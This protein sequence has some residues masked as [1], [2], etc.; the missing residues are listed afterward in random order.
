MLAKSFANLYPR[1]FERYYILQSIIEDDS[2]FTISQRAEK[3]IFIFTVSNLSP[4]Q[5]KLRILDL[6]SLYR[7]SYRSNFSIFFVYTTHTEYELQLNNNF[8]FA[9]SMIGR[10]TKIEVSD[11]VTSSPACILKKNTNATIKIDFEL[12][13]FS[14][15][16]YNIMDLTL[17]IYSATV[18]RVTEITAHVSGIVVGIEMPFTLPNS[19]GCDNSGIICPIQKGTTYEYST[20]LPVLKIYPKVCLHLRNVQIW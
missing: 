11:C 13:E 7:S 1:L 8:N 5:Q 14:L 12:S 9:G 17:W 18:D 2:N 20:T 19:N 16:V 15:N 6:R 10:F 4:C 3:R